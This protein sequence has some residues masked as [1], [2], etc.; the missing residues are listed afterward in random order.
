M[1]IYIMI[2]GGCLTNVYTDGNPEE[3]TVNLV[4]YDDIAAETDEAGQQFA[5]EVDAA[6][7]SGKLK[8]CW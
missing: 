2:R 8:A 6:I 5:D 1:E 4:D 3:V 7:T